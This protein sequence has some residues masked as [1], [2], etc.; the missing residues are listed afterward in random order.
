MSGMSVI[1][2]SV[3]YFKAFC[4]ISVLPHSMFIDFILLHIL[5]HTHRLL[6]AITLAHGWHKECL[7]MRV[8][9]WL[10]VMALLDDRR[11]RKSLS[12]AICQIKASA[13]CRRA[14][15]V[16]RDRLCGR[17]WEGGEWL[18]DSYTGCSLARLAFY[19]GFI[20]VVNLL[21]LL[22]WIARACIFPRLQV[23]WDK[24]IHGNVF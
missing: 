17:I 12:M 14:R 24:W 18:V 16:S 2:L 19:F 11:R 23:T 6:F 13:C 4:V 21:F 9:V 15:E 20:P 8:C 7:C 10:L 3:I 1:L 5:K 22:R